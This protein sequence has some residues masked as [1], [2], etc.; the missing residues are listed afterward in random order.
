MQDRHAKKGLKRIFAGLRPVGEFGM[1]LRIGKIERLRR[2]GNL[3]DQAFTHRKRG[4]VNGFRIKA[5]GCEQLQHATA[6]EIDR[7]DLAHHVG[8]NERDQPVEPLLRRTLLGHE[9]A[10]LAKQEPRARRNVCATARLSWSGRL[11]VIG[12]YLITRS[13]AGRRRTISCRIEP[14]S[15]MQ[16]THRKLDIFRIDQDADLDLGR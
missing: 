13:G 11:S 10:H 2:A 5:L 14:V 12:S 9:R 16:R 7:G 15:R 3:A 1:M 6:D 8:G 4:A